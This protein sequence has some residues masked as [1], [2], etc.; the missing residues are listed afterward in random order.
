M[1]VENRDGIIA[2]TDTADGTPVTETYNED[3]L[4]PVA[5]FAA[6]H[7][8]FQAH[9]AYAVSNSMGLLVQISEC[10][11]AARTL[12]TGD[13]PE[14]T[15]WSEIVYEDLDGSGDLEPTFEAGGIT[16]QLSSVIRL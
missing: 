4:D 14:L 7:H 12:R 1:I 2:V 15:D 6:E 13:R 3:V 9:G 16:V 10:G 11:T 8:G 5:S